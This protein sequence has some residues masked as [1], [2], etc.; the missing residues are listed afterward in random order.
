[1]GL[2]IIVSSNLFSVLS[3]LLPL[4]SALYPLNLLY[5]LVERSQKLIPNLPSLDVS[6]FLA[7]WP[8][9]EREG[10]EEPTLIQHYHRLTEHNDPRVLMKSFNV[11]ETS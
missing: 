6:L 9:K 1:M 10:L 5:G 11:S 8:P 4:I 7:L 3:A 2:S